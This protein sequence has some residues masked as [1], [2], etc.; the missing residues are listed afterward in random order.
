MRARTRATTAGGLHGRVSSAGTRSSWRSRS[1]IRR[2]YGCV[3]RASGATVTRKRTA[4]AAVGVAAPEPLPVRS[5]VQPRGA[6]SATSSTSA[7]PSAALV[8][9]TVDAERL[10]RDD[11]PVLGERVDREA[12]ST[13]ERRLRVRLLVA[14]AFSQLHARVGVGDERVEALLDGAHGAEGRGDRTGGARRRR[15]VERGAR[16]L[17]LRLRLAQR[18]AEL[19]GLRREAHEAGHGGVDPVE[20]VALHGCRGELRLRVEERVDAL[21]RPRVVGELPGALAALQRP[22]AAAELLPRLAEQRVV[23]AGRHADRRAERAL[24]RA[25][26]PAVVDLAGLP[27][28]QPLPQLLGEPRRV[29]RGAEGVARELAD[30]EV[31]LAAPGTLERQ[32]RGSRPAGTHGRRAPRRRA[33][34]RVPTSRTSPRR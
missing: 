20:D 9:F 16:G 25:A 13:R 21:R 18:R 29:G 32:G 28:P 23:D 10:A 14:Q 3:G 5:T 33:S 31:V 26:D 6:S 4:T 22:G 8:T 17:E 24:G 15:G 11:E 30:G 19:R 7:G 1:L 12:L 2:Q 34:P 27:G